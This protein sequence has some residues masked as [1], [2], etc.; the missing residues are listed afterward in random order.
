MPILDSLFELFKKKPAREDIDMEMESITG[1]DPGEV[2]GDSQSALNQRSPAQEIAAKY[3][4]KEAQ[5][6]R[7]ADANLLSEYSVPPP[8]DHSSLRLERGKGR[9]P[10]PRPANLGA[11]ADRTDGE[12]NANFPS[13]QHLQ[14]EEQENR[15]WNLA[16]QLAKTSFI[17]RE[18]GEIFTS[19]GVPIGSVSNGRIKMEAGTV[20]EHIRMLKEA[21][22]PGVTVLP[23]G[24]PNSKEL[25]DRMN[26]EL[27]AN[28]RSAAIFPD[29][30][31]SGPRP[32]STSPS[33]EPASISPGPKPASTS[34]SNG[35]PVGAPRT[36]RPRQVA[37]EPRR[38]HR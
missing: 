14:G 7:D 15:T 16:Q 1:A 33:L 29:A 11:G 36:N 9:R 4:E 27:M 25:Q 28:N 37:A 6:R 21:G 34:S 19:Q 2:R 31:S 13:S 10:R 18:N 5:E 32:V 8:P 30:R 26:R 3:R 35:M 24:D 38:P 17:I 12:G 23:V 22:I 20:N